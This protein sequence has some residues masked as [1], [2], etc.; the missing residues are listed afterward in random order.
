MLIR[1]KKTLNPL[2]FLEV[3]YGFGSEFSS[4]QCKE[5]NVISTW[6]A[7]LHDRNTLD[8]EDGKSDSFKPNTWDYYNSTN[9]LNPDDKQQN[10]LRTA[11]NNITE[12]YPGM[13]GMIFRK[14]KD[15][16]LWNLI[17]QLIL[18]LSTN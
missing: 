1:N 14:R 9:T 13:N 8:A 15:A 11:I 18:F 12:I 7:M 10:C 17:K 4:S 2:N 16:I 5:S 3:D 6:T